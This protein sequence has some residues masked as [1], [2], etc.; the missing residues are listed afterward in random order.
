MIITSL[1]F[2]T[3]SVL[4]LSNTL[5]ITSN[6]ISLCCKPDY[7]S[8]SSLIISL[9]VDS[10]KCS[11]T[12]NLIF[13]NASTE[14]ALFSLHNYLIF[15]I[16]ATVTEWNRYRRVVSTEEWIANSIQDLNKEFQCK[17]NVRGLTL[18]QEKNM[19]LTSGETNLNIFVVQAKISLKLEE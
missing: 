13:L 4:E 14:S 15:P 8:N 16:K 6:D 12:T 10:W 18:Q 19:F 9:A 7:I 2:S 3:S 5:F 17:G 1:S 11:Q